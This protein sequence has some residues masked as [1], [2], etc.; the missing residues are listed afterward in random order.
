MDTIESMLRWIGGV[1]ALVVIIIVL[2][3]V[4]RFRFSAGWKD[5]RQFT[6]QVVFTCLPG[7]LLLD[8]DRNLCAALAADPDDAAALGSGHRSGFGCPVLLFRHRL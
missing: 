8:L 1:A 6:S 2:I 7:D 3:S 4:R 5:S